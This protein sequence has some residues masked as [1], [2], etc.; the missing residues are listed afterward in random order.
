[1]VSSWESDWRLQGSIGS[2]KWDGFNLPQY[3]IVK[4][5]VKKFVNDFELKTVEDK[6]LSREGHLGCLDEMFD[7]LI[8]NRKAETDC[9]DNI[10]SM[11]MVF[12]ALKSSKEQRKVYLKELYNS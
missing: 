8:N 1:M 12:G 2:A 3:E 10:K 7:A 6:W 5:G 9:T 4:P 11:A